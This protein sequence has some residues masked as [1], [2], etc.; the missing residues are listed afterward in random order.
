MADLKVGFASDLVLSTYGTFCVMSKPTHLRCGG[1]LT[2]RRFITNAEAMNSDGD[3][4][5]TPMCGRGA[6]PLGPTLC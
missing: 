3:L 5:Q 1:H 6:R 2:D 4:R